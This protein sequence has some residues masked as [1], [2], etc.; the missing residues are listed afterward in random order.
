MFPRLG[1]VHWN[2]SLPVHVEIRPAVIARDLA[3]MLVAGERKSNLE[4]RRNPL[5]ARHRDEKG[6]EVGAIPLLGVAGMKHVATP[7]SSSSF[8][9]AQ[10]GEDVVVDGPCLV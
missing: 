9:V 4:S 10:R 8:V 1:N 7:P 2:P 3:R 5:R 6:M